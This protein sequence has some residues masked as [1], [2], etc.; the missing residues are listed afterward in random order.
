MPDATVSIP[1]TPTPWQQYQLALDDVTDRLER[2]TGALTTAGV[3]HALVGGQAVAL[4]VAT[5]DSAAVR[6]TKDVDLLIR[7]ADLPAAK[8]AARSIGMEYCEILG[9]GMFLESSDPNPCKAVK[10]LW[11]A[12]RVCADD[13]LL[14]PRVDSCIELEP[15][16]SAV[17]LADL[18]TMKLMANRDQDRVHL[19]DIIDVELVDRSMQAHLPA[20]LALR[21]DDLLTDAGL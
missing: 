5:R 3:P 19:R 11:A 7:K 13:A 20:E 12:E 8:K 10:L 2:I 17:P 16:K 14:S 15:G 6:T 1:S 9:V 4:W 18:V 21:L